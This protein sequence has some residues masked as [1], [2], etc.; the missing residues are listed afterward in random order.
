VWYDVSHTPHHLE[1][2]VSVPL[3]LAER[4]LST[5]SAI[6]EP[7]DSP[8]GQLLAAARAQLVALILTLHVGAS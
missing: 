8:T 4:A 5:V 6:T 3:E 7:D 2:T 1:A